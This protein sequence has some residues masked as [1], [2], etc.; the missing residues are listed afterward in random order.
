MLYIITIMNLRVCT[1]GK[2][3]GSGGWWT[4]EERTHE[5]A[6]ATQLLSKSCRIQKSKQLCFLIVRGNSCLATK[7]CRK[8][9]C[10]SNCPI[11][12]SFR[13]NMIFQRQLQR[14][15]FL[16]ILDLSPDAQ[17]P[18]LWDLTRCH[19]LV[20]L[21]W[22]SSFTL[23]SQRILDCT[24]FFFFLLRSSWQ[25]CLCVNGPGREISMCRNP[26]STSSWWQSQM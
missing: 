2:S 10:H 1:P 4:S 5:S 21:K 6:G 13:G 8:P 20:K 15:W 23:G 14:L 12:V 24:F 18:M 7:L 3:V 26:E 25:C 16:H 17:I 22:L 9:R 19:D 11:N